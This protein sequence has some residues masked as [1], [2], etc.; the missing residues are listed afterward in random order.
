MG[1]PVVGGRPIAHMEQA[2]LFCTLEILGM[3]SAW[4]LFERRTL[5]PPSLLWVL[6]IGL[7][8]TVV[9]TQSRVGIVVA[10]AVLAVCVWRGRD[11]AI[12]QRRTMLFLVWAVCLAGMLMMPSLNEHIGIVGAPLDERMSGGRRPLLWMT[13]LEAIALKPG[14][15]WGVLQNGEAQYAV[16]VE[17]PSLGWTFSSAHDLPLDLMLWFGV[18]VGLTTTVVLVAATLMRLARARNMP[19]LIIA[20]CVLSLLLHAL[21]E[22]PLHYLHYLLLFALMLGLSSVDSSPKLEFAFKLSHPSVLPLIAA[23]PALLLGAVAHEYIEISDTRPILDIDPTTKHL[24][25]TAPLPPPQVLLLDQLQAFHVMA[26][27]PLQPGLPVRRLDD[28]RAPLLRYPFAPS[29]EHYARVMALNGRTD[30]AL[31][32]LKRLC[33]VESE[34][35]CLVSRL[36][37]HTWRERGELLPAWP[38]ER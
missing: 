10:S 11:L 14:M 19:T 23:T 2:N 22:F 37:W 12:G 29:I 28:M 6:Q 26:A 5:L 33:K 31:Q 30:E 9:L 8:L 35:S 3:L 18:P 4:R 25:L 17:H 36:A 20:L 24:V 16:A 38:D 1:V 27:V 15:G 34:Q 7:L 13:M 32:A 21:V